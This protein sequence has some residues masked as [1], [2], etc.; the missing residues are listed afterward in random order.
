MRN[1]EGLTISLLEEVLVELQRS[2][3][4]P[5]LSYS[6]GLQK[7]TGVALS[8]TSPGLTLIH[9]TELSIFFLHQRRSSKEGCAVKILM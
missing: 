6:Y 3:L 5:G 4:V 8:L 1:P 9:N 2:C 7:H